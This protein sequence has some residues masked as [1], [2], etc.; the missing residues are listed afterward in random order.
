MDWWS[1]QAFA[2][3][4]LMSCK[5]ML[6]DEQSTKCLPRYTAHSLHI[7]PEKGQSPASFDTITVGTITS[8]HHAKSGVVLTFYPGSLKPSAMLKGNTKLLTMFFAIPSSQAPRPCETWHQKPRVFECTVEGGREH[9]FYGPAD[10]TD[11]LDARCRQS[12][13]ERL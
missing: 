6:R 5:W 11:H 1:V 12:G 9:L 13:L 8:L 4:A 3:A 10:E 2:F 7:F